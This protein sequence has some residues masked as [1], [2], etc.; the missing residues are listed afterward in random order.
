MM[1]DFF[2]KSLLNFFFQIF[3]RDNVSQPVG[4]W[5]FMSG[6]RRYV[7]PIFLTKRKEINSAILNIRHFENP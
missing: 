6:M 5:N 1:D 4:L 7:V 2:E 3:E